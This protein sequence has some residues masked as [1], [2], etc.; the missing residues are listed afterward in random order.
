MTDWSEGGP[1]PYQVLGFED[2]LDATA[3]EIKKVRPRGADA[4]A[5]GVEPYSIAGY[6][7]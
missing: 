3:D 2:G 4:C 5:H 1:T 6:V 7:C